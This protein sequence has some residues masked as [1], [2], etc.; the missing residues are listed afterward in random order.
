MPSA[1]Y[2]RMTIHSL[3]DL[4]RRP[5]GSCQSL[6]STTRLASDAWQIRRDFLFFYSFGLVTV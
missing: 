3:R 4:K 5:R 2:R 6:K 1:P